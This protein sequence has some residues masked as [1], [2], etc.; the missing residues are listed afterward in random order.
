MKRD[1]LSL[2]L[3]FLILLS[4]VAIIGP[5]MVRAHGPDIKVRGELV[6]ISAGD[7]VWYFYVRVTQVLTSVDWPPTVGEVYPADWWGAQGYE[8]QIDWSVRVGDQVE[9]YAEWIDEI[10][11]LKQP[12]HYLKKIG[13]APPSEFEV[14]VEIKDPV[15]DVSVDFI[16]IIAGR[17]GVTKD[18]THVIASIVLRNIPAQLYFN[19]PDTPAKTLEYEWSLYIDVDGNP[20]TGDH[21]GMDLGIGLMHFKL[22]ETP[23]YAS[24]IEGTQ[25]N[26]WIFDS[27]SGTW[28]YGEKITVTADFNSNTLTMSARLSQIIS[29]TSNF[30]FVAGYYHDAEYEIDHASSF[31]FSISVSPSSRT[32]GQGEAATFGVTVTS[33]TGSIQTVSL[34]LTGHHETMSYRFDPSSGN[35]TFAST[36]TVTTSTSTPVGTYTLTITGTDGGKTHSTTVELV[37]VITLPIPLDKLKEVT[38]KR[39][40]I[41]SRFLDAFDSRSKLESVLNEL[42]DLRYEMI[43]ALLPSWKDLIPGVDEDAK[44]FSDLLEYTIETFDLLVRANQAY[45]LSA[46]DLK[47]TVHIMRDPDMKYLEPPYVYNELKRMLALLDA[48][49]AAINSG[50]ISRV[51]SALRQELEEAHRLQRLLEY[52][53]DE[54]SSG[55][56]SVQIL[57]W[58]WIGWWI[59]KIPWPVWK[60][61]YPI[62]DMS[63]SVLGF[64]KIEIEWLS[65][66]TE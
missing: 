61:M 55:D 19:K 18:K 29:S 32:V 51:K 48:E 52:A 65:Q 63:N 5:V 27:T 3:V 7:G 39:K 62:R 41:Y 25:H 13:Y 50:D 46:L 6:R 20:Q 24:L 8:G 66:L 11:W 28:D 15:G 16:D 38:S 42:K 9:V 21:D 26:T 12:Y 45:S 14:L 60:T 33:L 4:T 53:R 17:I 64:L 35:P 56:L 36:L 37:V 31:D 58:E 57:V 44:A 10:L 34:S 22:K 1:F 59:F 43:N 23:Y 49:E 47:L 30:V 2:A 54:G 40:E